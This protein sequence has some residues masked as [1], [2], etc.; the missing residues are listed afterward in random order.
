MTDNDKITVCSHCKLA[1]CWDGEFMCQQ[2]KT[3]DIEVLTVGE[4]KKLDL[5]HPSY[6]ERQLSQ[7]V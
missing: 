5:E 6:W 1:T 7:N 2:S 3:A 4:L